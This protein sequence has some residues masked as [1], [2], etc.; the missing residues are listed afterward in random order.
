MMPTTSEA[1][2]QCF[3]MSMGGFG[4]VW[5]S[6]ESTNHSIIG[7]VTFFKRFRFTIYYALTHFCVIRINNDDESYFYLTKAEKCP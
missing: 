3:L 7:K 2:I 6:L 1:I 5:S 4:G